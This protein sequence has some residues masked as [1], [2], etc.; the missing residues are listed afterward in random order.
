MARRHSCA[1]IRA[2]VGRCR[3][4]DRPWGSILSWT[5]DVSGHDLGGPRFAWALPVLQA[6]ASEKG[7]E[8]PGNDQIEH[9]ATAIATLGLLALYLKDQDVAYRDTLLR[10]A[11]HQGIPRASVS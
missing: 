2:G 10:L 3:T 9:N 5:V 1:L 7:K 8:H 11:A 4:S 6:A